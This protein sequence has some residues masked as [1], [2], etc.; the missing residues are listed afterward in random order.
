MLPGRWE[1]RAVAPF[2]TWVANVRGDAYPPRESPR[3]RPRDGCLR[4]RDR[5]RKTAG[6]SGPSATVAGQSALGSARRLAAQD[7]LRRG[8]RPHR[9]ARAGRRRPGGVVRRCRRPHRA[10][11]RTGTRR[12]ARRGRPAPRVACTEYAPARVKQAVCGYGR[13]DK[14][15][16]SADGEGI[17]SCSDADRRPHAADALAVAICHARCRRSPLVAGGAGDRAPERPPA[18]AHAGGL[19]L[20]VNGVGYL[21]AA[22]PSVLRRAEGRRG[23]GRD[24][25]PRARGRAPALRLRRRGGAR[26]LRAAPDGQR[27][28]P[29][30]RARRRLRLPGR[31]AP[32]GDRA[33]RPRALPGDPRDREEDRGAN[34]ARAQGEDRL[35]SSEPT[36]RPG[37]GHPA[38]WSPATRSS[39]SATPWSRPSSGSPAVDPEPAARGARPAGAPGAAA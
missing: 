14:G 2:C 35:R 21:V 36:L 19:V 13:A 1:H 34:R 16:V 27:H 25:P 20:D 37:G 32:P 31:G 26:A 18:V 33:R 8:H 23:D 9:R 24:V 15:Q 39:S 38:T 29:E 30:G 4:I 10:L 7:D 3:H 12:R 17:C 11:R 28:R 22:T 6:A 5:P